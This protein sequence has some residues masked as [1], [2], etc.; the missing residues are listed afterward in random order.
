[1][2]VEASWNEQA[3]GKLLDLPLGTPIRPQIET[4]I[5]AMREAIKDA[6]EVLKSVPAKY[7]PRFFRVGRWAD[8]AL[9]KLQSFLAEKP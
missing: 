1:M 5:K 2:Q 6:Y 7:D 3:V 4:A 9:T 8:T